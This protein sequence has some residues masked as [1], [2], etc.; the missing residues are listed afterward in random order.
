MG[1]PPHRNDDTVANIDAAN[2]LEER[3][4]RYRH[5]IRAA[6]PPSEHRRIRGMDRALA[7]IVDRCLAV[8][9]DDRFANVQE[10]L[11]ALAARKLNRSRLPL[12][13]IGFVGPLLI[14]LVTSFF[15]FEGYRQAVIDAE[16]GYRQWALENNEFAAQLA[17]EK[18]TGQLSR[19]FEIAREEAENADFL[20]HFFSV[21]TDSPAL[22][23]L[24]DSIT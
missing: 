18:V 17:A 19:Y 21:V 22:K 1:T 2:E 13:V 10:V 12:M 15:S 16:H 24:N 7:E 6:P 23:G 9:P 5:A 20:K 4:A 11:D 3:L 14:L 8:N